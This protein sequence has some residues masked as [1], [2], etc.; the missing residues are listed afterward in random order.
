MFFYISLFVGSL[1]AAFL[2]LY[3][4][5]ALLHAGKAVHKAWFADTKENLTG[6]LDGTRLGAS[7]NGAQTPWG[8]KSHAT[9]ENSARTHPASANTAGLDAFLKNSLGDSGSKVSHKSAVRW[10]QREDKKEFTGK[11]YK[12]TRQVKLQRTNLKETAKP[13]GW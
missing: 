2:M 5:N 6:H 13:W 7:S 3:L 8:W 10:P 4:Y 9:P 1:I 11:A 12:V